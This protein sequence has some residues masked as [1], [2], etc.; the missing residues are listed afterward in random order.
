MPTEGSS[1]R[2]TPDLW[3]VLIIVGVSCLVAV[4]L[5]LFSWI[6]FYKRK[7]YAV[8]QNQE[9]VYDSIDDTMATTQPASDQQRT[10]EHI[11]YLATYPGV[12]MTDNPQC[13]Y[14]AIDPPK[15]NS[16]PQERVD[17]LCDHIKKPT[18]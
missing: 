12:Q 10:E 7:G 5:V 14:E 4:V 18:K 1:E 15:E 11:Y 13:V 17:Q 9:H 6:C 16:T 8:A 3:K 2:T